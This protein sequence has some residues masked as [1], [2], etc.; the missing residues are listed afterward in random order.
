MKLGGEQGKGCLGFPSA[1]PYF[2]L[3]PQEQT[4]R[5]SGQWEVRAPPAFYWGYCGLGWDAWEGCRRRRGT[6]GDVL[7]WSQP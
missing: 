5:L 7:L 2:S 6:P 4:S 1:R 3:I